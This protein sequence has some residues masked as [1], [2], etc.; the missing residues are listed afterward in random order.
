MNS[1]LFLYLNLVRGPQ[2][3]AARREK[4][5]RD[6]RAKLEADIASGKVPKLAS[7]KRCDAPVDRL[8]LS[9]EVTPTCAACII[10][11]KNELR[12]ATKE[13]RH[14]FKMSPFLY[15]QVFIILLGLAVFCHRNVGPLF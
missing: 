5:E 12:V 10:K 9:L 7:C 1:L 6:K 8:S 11:E 15:F 13:M 4:E 14:A 2:I 3:V